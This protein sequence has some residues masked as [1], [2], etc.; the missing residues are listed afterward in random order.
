MRDVGWNDKIVICGREKRKR[1]RLTIKKLIS[2]KYL[3]GVHTCCAVNQSLPK[4]TFYHIISYIVS[5]DSIILTEISISENIL[6]YCIKYCINCRW[7]ISSTLY[8]QKSNMDRTDI[9][10]QHNANPRTKTENTIAA[11]L[12][13][14]GVLLIMPCTGRLRRLK[15]V[16]FQ[17]S[18]I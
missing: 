10:A 12:V 2:F 1:G 6:C 13:T 18:G 4:I 8:I 11:M 5:F 17:A 9:F 14:P 7:K 3:R 16:A 15:E